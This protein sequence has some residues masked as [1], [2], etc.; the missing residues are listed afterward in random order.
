MATPGNPPDVDSNIDVKWSGLR[1]C[2]WPDCA[3][4]AT[5]HSRVSLKAHIRNIHVTPLVCTHPSCSYKKPFGKPCDLKR[6]MATIHNTE[7]QYPCLESDC[8]EE[9]HQLFKCPYIHYSATVFATQRES[10]LRE[11]YGC[12]ECAIGSCASAHRSFFTKE[13]LRRH[14]RTCHRITFNPVATIMRNLTAGAKED[15]AVYANSPLRPTYRDCASCLPKSN[16]Q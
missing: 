14:L 9:K 8:Q 6:H 3:S 2:H 7:R 15:G 12:Y 4:K 10:H 5:F 1:K 11:S 16:E 13:N